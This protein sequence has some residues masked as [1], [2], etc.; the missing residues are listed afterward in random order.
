MFKAE[1]FVVLENLCLNCGSRI[2]RRWDFCSEGC[3]RVFFKEE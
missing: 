3:E 1:G 2:S